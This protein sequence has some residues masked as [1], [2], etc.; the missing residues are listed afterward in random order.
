[1][2][3]YKV[4]SSDSHI[5][6]PADL[7]EKRIDPRFRDRAPRIVFED[8]H[9]QW[10]CD[11]VAFGNIGANQQAGVRFED[12][13]KLNSFG[14]MDTVPLGGID[15]DAHVKDLDMD[16]ISGGVL[17]PSQG[18][19]LWQ[20]PASDLLSAIF[21]AYNDYLAEFCNPHP[22]RLKGIAA[23]NVDFVEDAV[24]E[25]ERSAKL[26]LVGA[27]ISI[28][29]L[30][31]YDQSAYEKLWAMAEDLDMSLSLHTGTIRW[32]PGDGGKP[33]PGAVGFTSREVNVRQCIAAM[34]FSG[35]FERH[36]KLK[37]GVVEYEVAWAPYFMDR[38]DEFYGQRPGGVSASR[39][40]GELLPSDFFRSNVFISF[41][42]DDL[43]MELRHRIGVDTLMWGSDYPHA[44]STFPRSREILERILQ[45][46]P[47]DERA[48]IAGENTAGLYHFE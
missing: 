21:R 46:V 26:G 17:Y 6:E 33:T 41:Q 32:T 37:V 11:G 28:R 24:S 19:T 16:G 45:G 10:Y 1:M 29:P 2:S 31:P 38:M 35:V 48:K 4:W 15:P 13:E 34:I 30:L 5:I 39:F 44:E 25:L 8:G 18:L 27:M 20:I 23:I 3:S 12:P 43:G 47:E 22:D 42:E 40:K 36:P 7:W 14:V 9:D